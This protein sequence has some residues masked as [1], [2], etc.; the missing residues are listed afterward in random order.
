MTEFES[1]V[2]TVQGGDAERVEIIKDEEN[3]KEEETVPAEGKE[4]SA[5]VDEA[6]KT[7]GDEGKDVVITIEGEKTDS[8]ATCGDGDAVSTTESKRE[9]QADAAEEGVDV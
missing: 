9:N 8:D 4:S 6:V 7:P 2:A 1:A 5:V 3:K